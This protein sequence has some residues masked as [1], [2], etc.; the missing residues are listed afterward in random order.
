MLTDQDLTKLSST[1]QQVFATKQDVAEAVTGSEERIVSKFSDLQASV[2][3]YLKF[4]EAWHQELTILKGRQDKLA[5]VLID[6]GL[7][8]EK[9]LAL[10]G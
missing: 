10:I 6:K 9:E 5:R 1:L 2:D 4:T 7:V 3:R 8:S